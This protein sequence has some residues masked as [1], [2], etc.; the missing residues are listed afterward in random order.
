MTKKEYKKFYN[1]YL[2]SKYTKTI[3][4]QLENSNT[5]PDTLDVFEE[6]KKR[7]QYGKSLIY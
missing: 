5:T 6:N 3:H 7:F 4:K 2:K 1:K